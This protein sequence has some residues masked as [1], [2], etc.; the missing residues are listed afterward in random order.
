M[1]KKFQV[2]VSSTYSDLIE[3]RNEVMK[4][5]LELDCIPAGMELFPSGDDSVWS[6]I[7]KVID[8]CDYFIIISAGKYGSIAKNEKSY[9]QIEYEYA[10]FKNIPTISFLFHDLDKLLLEKSEKNEICKNKLIDFRHVLEK[11]LCRYW[12]NKNELAGLVSRSIVK[13]IKDKPA[14]GWIK[15][16]N[17]IISSTDD[18]VMQIFKEISQIKDFLKSNSYIK[19]FEEIPKIRSENR[20]LDKDKVELG[21]VG[22]TEASQQKNAYSLV[23]DNNINRKKFGIVIGAPEA[24]SIA[25][26]LE[27]IKPPRPITHDI[28]RVLFDTFGLEVTEVL[29]D[30]V[31][32]HIFYTILML[33][34]GL[35]TF[36]FDCRTSDGIAIA[37]R[38]KAP[39][40]TFLQIIEDVGV[41][42]DEEIINT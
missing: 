19:T 15:A 29:I 13:L 8:N 17:I 16:S 35:N 26:E 37:L 20:L 39:I 28:F 42:S 27:H 2:F 6:Y 5:L 33:S 14:I 38:C 7:Q 34:D 41:I 32:D 30:T 9:T 23:F 31:H 36:E 25:L 21:I 18:Q 1:D 11:K 4:A 12:N 40:F 22:I 24:Q 3:E 10:L